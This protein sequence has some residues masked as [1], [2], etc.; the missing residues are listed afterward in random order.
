MQVVDL[1]GQ[2]AHLLPEGAVWLPQS[3]CLLVADVH[4]GKAV[5]FRRLGVP[6]PRG[7]TADTL[8][9][10]SAL[11]AR[12][13]PAQLVFLGDLLHSRHVH[14][15]AVVDQVA[16]WRGAHST[17]RMLLV[18]GNH[19]DRAGDPPPQWQI[20]VVDEPWPLGPLALCHHPRCVPGAF[21]LAGHWHPCV[22]LTGRGRER[23]RLPCFWSRADML[24]LPAF[25]AFTGMHPIE[26]APGDRVYAL[27]EEA[28]VAVPCGTGR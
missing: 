8:D 10:L 3:G 28:V 14:A 23:L 13:E 15:S 20:D 12:L 16:A 21:V 5:S 11:L 17:V 19:D 25:G 1:M 6:V 22:S 7:T 4:L 9:R 27:T 2:S 24:L 26:P 18:R